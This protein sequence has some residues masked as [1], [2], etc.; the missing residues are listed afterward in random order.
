VDGD[1]NHREAVD[2]FARMIGQQV[3][4]LTSNFIVAE[5]HALFLRREGRYAA[6]RFLQSLTASGLMVERV[7]EDDEV[8]ARAII[9]QYADKDFSY[10]DATSFAL[11][12]RL[13][14]SYALSFD[15]HFLQFGLPAP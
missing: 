13:G 9:E 6:L 4:I 8:A 7:S 15:R 3:V 11:V 12:R 2:A 10:A 5:T 14:I 1:A